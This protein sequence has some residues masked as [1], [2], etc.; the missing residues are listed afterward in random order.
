MI[1][2]FLAPMKPP[3]HPVP[4]GDRTIA[5]HWIAALESLGWEVRLASRLRTV[6]KA[7]GE[8]AFEALF[9]QGAA[10]T[11]RILAD[12]ALIA[13]ARL[14]F[15]YHNYYR[16]PDCIGPELARA[17][18]VPY[19]VA[20]PSLAGK[21][22][23]GPHR[24]GEIRARA[25]VAAARLLVAA[26]AADRPLLESVRQP[27]QQI[28][29]I[30]AGLDPQAW[31]M[32]EAAA[33]RG[34]AGEGPVRLITVA[35]MREGAKLASYALL[36]EAMQAIATEDFILDIHGDGPARATVAA[37]F[38]RFGDRVRLHG[39]SGRDRLGE[40][41][42]TAD[43]CIW[44]GLQEAYGMAYLEAQLHGVPCLAGRIGGVPEAL[45]RE[46]VLVDAVTP[47]AYGAALRALLRDR[48]G[49][50]ERRA[51]V[52]RFILEERSLA[53]MATRFAQ[54]ARSAGIAPAGEGG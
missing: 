43:L 18:G 20:E 45:A 6:T 5:R 41:F 19:V 47:E 39:E 35:M 54:V 46:S 31:P 24:A 7:G 40:A 29:T 48:A 8:A 37:F 9:R 36:A 22:L 3:D 21:R 52:R 10:E 38:A 14:V 49:L 25:G 28:V 26:S 33:A 32:A 16:A 27:G 34:A 53:S 30:P 1:A 50:A 42:R 44:P 15:C 51:A 4:S 11:A 2:L 23:A 12:P 13:G 17:L